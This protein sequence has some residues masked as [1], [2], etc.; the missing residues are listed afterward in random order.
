MLCEISGNTELGVTV[1]GLGFMKQTMMYIISDREQLR[2]IYV[3]ALGKKGIGV[4]QLRTSLY[5][6]H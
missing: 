3:K 6:L 1:A 2:E 4:A 5:S